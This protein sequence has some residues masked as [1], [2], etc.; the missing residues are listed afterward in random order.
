MRIASASNAITSTA[1]IDGTAPTVSVET[2]M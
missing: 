2:V 1:I